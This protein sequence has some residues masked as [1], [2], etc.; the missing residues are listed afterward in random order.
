MCS[1]GL[2][3]KN[4]LGKA[5][6]CLTCEKIVHPADVEIALGRLVLNNKL[7]RKINEK[8]GQIWLSSELL[9]WNYNFQNVLNLDVSVL[10]SKNTKKRRWINICDLRATLVGALVRDAA[11]RWSPLAPVVLSSIV[12]KKGAAQNF[13]TTVKMNGTQINHAQINTPKF[14]PPLKKTLLLRP[15]VLFVVGKKNLIKNI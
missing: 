12:K 13:A 3:S 11:S 8:V 15:W 10:I 7:C 6:Q 1:S 4:I 14:Y 2:L 9:V 5:P